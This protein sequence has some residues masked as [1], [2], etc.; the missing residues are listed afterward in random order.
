MQYMEVHKH[1]SVGWEG[2][3][4]ALENE[5]GSKKRQADVMDAVTAAD[6]VCI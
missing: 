1:A 4:R 2:K 5:Y 3:H 6:T